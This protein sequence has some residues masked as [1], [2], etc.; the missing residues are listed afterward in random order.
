MNISP[1]LGV[2]QKGALLSGSLT[3]GVASLTGI[4]AA[5]VSRKKPSTIQYVCVDM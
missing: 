4:T 1:I 2:R 5:D 3:I